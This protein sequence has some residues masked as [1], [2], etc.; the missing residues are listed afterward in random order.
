M[1]YN[2]FSPQ[3]PPVFTLDSIGP[4]GIALG[5]IRAKDNYDRYY[6]FSVDEATQQKLPRID[7]EIGQNTNSRNIYNVKVKTNDYFNA[8]VRMDVETKSFPDVGNA[9]VQKITCEIIANGYSI[10]PVNGQMTHFMNGGNQTIPI[11]WDTKRV[12][13]MSDPTVD[14]NDPVFLMNAATNT[15]HIGTDGQGGMS[16]GA[17]ANGHTIDAKTGM[18]TSVPAMTHGHQE[19]NYGAGMFT[20]SLNFLQHYFIGLGVAVALP[21]NHMINIPKMLGIG[22]F[23]KNMIGSKKDNTG[24]YGLANALDNVVKK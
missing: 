22:K 9:N 14:L 10:P 21:M 11:I 12:F 15:A 17:G 7:L 1:E 16:F 20:T 8:I 19:T 4:S 6:D 23:V 5:V 18:S 3:A 24:I 13:S 2:I